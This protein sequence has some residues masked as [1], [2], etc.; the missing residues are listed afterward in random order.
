M[1]A[2]LLLSLLC[3]C[4][5]CCSAAAAVSAALLLCGCCAA[6]LYIHH[7]IHLIIPYTIGIYPIYIQYIHIVRY[8]FRHKKGKKRAVFCPASDKKIKPR[9]RDCQQSESSKELPQGHLEPGT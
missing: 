3:C 7:T 1:S 5:L 4:C 9:L 8:V 6:L 2:L